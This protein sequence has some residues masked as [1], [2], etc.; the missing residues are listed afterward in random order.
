MALRALKLGTRRSLLARAQSAA[1]A[2]Q[3]QQLYPDLAV[4]LIG[5]DTRGDRLL[6]TPLSS[7]EGKEFFTDELDAALLDGRVDFTVHSYK[8]LSL[9]RSAR[10]R[11]AAVPR[12]QWPHDLVVF[13]H[14]VPA[15]LAAGHELRIGSSSPRRASFVPDF[16]QR[17][18]PHRGSDRRS[19]AR[20]QLVDV[21]GNVDTRLRR[22]HEARGSSRHLDGIVLA[23]AG[24]ARL[25]M[26]GAGQ[27]LLRELFAPLPHMLLP[28]SECPAAPAQGAL[29]LEC[30]LDDA[31]TA[32]L[33]GALDHAA[34]RRAVTAERA[35]LALRGGGCQQRFGATQIDLPGLGGL[36]Y[37]RSGEAPD[38]ER[39]APPPRWSPDSP[40]EAPH[41]AIR[42]WDGSRAAPAGAEALAA[43]IAE[44]AEHL[45]STAAVFVA[46]RLAWPEGLAVPIH[47]FPRIWVPGTA[48]WR[49]LA[50][51]GV[52]VEGCADG[53]GFA[54]LEPLLAEPLLQLPLTAGWTVLTHRDALAGWGAAEVIATYRHPDPEPAPAVDGAPPADATHLYWSSGAQFER[55]GKRSA[56][57]AQ[58]ACG[59]GRTY[60][61]LRRAGVQNLRL[62]PQPAHWR[63]WLGL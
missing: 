25:W 59:P 63:Q 5:I 14:D 35:L 37:E 23:V 43:G 8:D 60:E 3:L 45:T 1:V 51:C 33:L 16:L 13:A 40:L 44:A 17:S 32:A 36:M 55:W 50:A 61:H 58:H 39:G 62:F 31:P 21:R 6:D 52:W 42:P 38:M 11:L 57:Q 41:G 47:A 20:V 34:T 54:A 29:A 7:V 56:G 15:R 22:L 19:I 48:T 9:D 46:H 49:A 26:D 10:L 18:L 4:E 12:R 27:A 30:R 2:G 24:L 53:L 28:L